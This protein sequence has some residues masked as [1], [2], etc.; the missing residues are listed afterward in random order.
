LPNS[1]TMI[2]ELR[3]GIEKMARRQAVH[4]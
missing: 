2:A 1:G 3:S 4:L